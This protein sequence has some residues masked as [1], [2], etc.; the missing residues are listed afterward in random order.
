MRFVH[1]FLFKLIALCMVCGGALIA[2][3]WW[4]ASLRAM[5]FSA[6]KI[7]VWTPYGFAFGLVAILAG[8]IGLWPGRGAYRH[9]VITFPGVHGDVT[10]ELDSVESTLTRMVNKMPEVKKIRIR[11][12][13]ADDRRRVRVKADVLV[14]KGASPS[15]AREIANRITDYLTDTAV[16]ML[17]VE[18]VT[19]VDLNVRGIVMDAKPVPPAKQEEHATHDEAVPAA[20]A[21]AVSSAVPSVQEQEPV[22]ETSVSPQEAPAACESEGAWN[23]GE[24]KD[25]PAPFDGSMEDEVAE[26]AEPAA[27]GVGNEWSP[28]TEGE[29]P[30]SDAEPPID[31]GPVNGEA[32]KSACDDR[33]LG[34]FQEWNAPDRPQTEPKEE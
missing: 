33:P 21:V 16:N 29:S 5:I 10:I 9:N 2:A 8:L 31:R 17:G 23:R 1:R 22:A 11:V 20:A 27:D 30:A 26:G 19:T 12:V 6:F 14:Y 34:G 13:P 4:D 15:S 3:M 18:D 24:P 28:V 25:T 7:H 32:D